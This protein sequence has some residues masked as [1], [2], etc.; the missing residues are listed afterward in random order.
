ML[1]SKGPKKV[2]NPTH[3]KY[4]EYVAEKKVPHGAGKG[5]KKTKK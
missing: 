3:S 4:A 2:K 5:K 1:K